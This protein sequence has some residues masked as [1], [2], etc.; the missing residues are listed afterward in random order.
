M[1][2]YATLIRD[3][4]P[5]E[6]PRERMERLG[7]DAL[8]NAELLAIIL[9][10]GNTKVSAIQLAQQ[11]LSHFGSLRKLANATV[12]ELSQLDGIGLA[13]ACQLKSAF[14][15]GKRLATSGEIT[16]PVITS[17]L[18]AANLVMEE[19]RYFASEHFRVIFLDTRHQV[20]GDRDV[21][22]G[23][24]NASMVHPRETFKAAIAHTAAAVILVHNHP[25]G[26]PTPSQE[27]VAIT[28]RL[29]EVGDLIGIPVL[30]HLVIGDGR[31]IS[32]KE[33]GLM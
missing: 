13:K 30:D 25:S 14:E 4:P 1:S 26:D 23:T 7:P 18:I 29:Q 32:I 8:A 17:P 21:S 9:R 6:R 10:V 3:L 19:M 33:R 27:D 5:D 28:K 15:L 31:F 2:E 24:L 11:L 22:I 16:R 12:Q 20:I